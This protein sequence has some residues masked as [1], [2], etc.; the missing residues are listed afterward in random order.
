M[1]IKLLTVLLMT[2]TG[3]A[4]AANLGDIYKLARQHDPIY[5]SAYASYKAGLEKLPQ[6]QALLCPTIGLNANVQHVESDSSL[7]TGG[8]KSYNPYG[9]GLSLQQP[10]YRKQNL[11]TYEQGKLQVMLAESQLKVAEQ[12]LILRVAKAYFDVLQ[13]Q[14]NVGTS[15][16]KKNAIAEQL[17]QAK[18]SFDV[19][20]AT[21]TDTHEAQ[22]RFDLAAAQEIAARNDLEVKRQALEKLIGASAPK[23]AVLSGDVKSPDPQPNDIETW[24][25]QSQENGL[26]VVAGRTAEEIARQE[27][28]KQRAG[29]LPTLDL[30]ASYNDSRN[31]V[32]GSVTKIDS[33]SAVLGVQLAWAF[34]QGGAVEA[35]VREAQANHE[36]ARFDLDNATAQ[37]ALDAR[38]AFLGVVS[39]NA[40]SKALAQAVVSTESQLQSTKLGLEVGVRTRVDVLNAQQQLYAAQ[41]DLAAARYEAIKSGLSLKAATAALT[42]ADLA[43]WD[44]FL[45]ES[46]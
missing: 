11:A 7:T 26:A 10:L 16:A 6:T 36:K 42:E 28:V 20:A 14:D 25:R 41:R 9:F 44:A 12:D 45:R 37:A 22:A 23:L 4:H 46:K 17:A 5:A 35:R 30:V 18:F 15:E 2:A 13:A 27:V 19:G 34:Y 31:G 40:R 39:G 8:S 21:I 29:G 43:A 3:A 32:S 38:N 33:Q 24:V 1:H